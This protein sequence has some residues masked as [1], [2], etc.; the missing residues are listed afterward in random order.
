MGGFSGTLGLSKSKSKSVTNPWSV[1]AP[2]LEWGFNQAQ[3]MAKQG[4]NPYQLQAAD[5]GFSNAMQI[6]GP[7]GDMMRQYGR[8]M[9]PALGQA[10]GF[11]GDVLSGTAGQFTNPYAGDQYNQIREN[12]WT[13]AH[14]MQAD[15]LR[16][17]TIEGLRRS[18]WGDALGASLAGVGVG[19]ESSPYMRARLQSEENAMRGYQAQLAGM[20][21]NAYG[22]AL[23]VA[24]NFAGA[25]LQNQYNGFGNQAAAAGNLMAMGNQGFGLMQGGYGMTQQGAQDAGGW[26]DYQ[27]SA[28]WAPLQ[29][30][31]NIAGGQSWGSSTK[32]KSSSTGME[33]GFG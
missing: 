10:Q 2:F 22:Q 25:D 20:H 1:Q 26:G 13:P 4:P 14:Q 7:I 23:G 12:Y 6:A 27:Q 32:G 15:A 8:A 11:Y 9:A 16:S 3:D 29:N 28:M 18:D 21:G 31:W 5:Y 33:F 17:D 19:Q 24:N 30:Y